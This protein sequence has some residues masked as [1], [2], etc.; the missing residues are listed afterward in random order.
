MRSR[1]LQSALADYIEAAGSHLQAEIVAGAE[2][3]YEVCS[4]AGRR[5]VVGTPLYCYRA[6]TGTFI[7]ERDAALKRL[8]GHADAA[9]ALEGFDGLE[10]YL[11]QRGADV[12]PSRGRARVRKAMSVL[13]EDVFAEQ[14][15]FKVRPERVRAAIGKLE[16]SAFAGPSQLTLVATL[17][18]LAICSPELQLAQGLAIANPEAIDGVPQQAST[19]GLDGAPERHLLVVHAAEEGDSASGLQRGRELLVE[20]L[21]ALRLFGDGRVTLGAVGWMRV[22]AGE[23]SPVAIGEGGRP[24]GMLLVTV[25]QE[26]ELRAFCNLIARRARRRDAVAWALRRFELGCGRDSAEEALS[27]HLLALR[28]LLEPEG[29]ASALLG[30]RLAALCATPERRAEMAERVRQAVALE[31]TIIAGG[32]VK[33][34]TAKALERELAGHLRALLS[35]VI[36][37]HLDPDLATLA[38]ELML[39][40]VDSSEDAA[41]APDDGAQD[42]GELLPDADEPGTD[43]GE[44]GAD[45]PEADTA[46]RRTPRKRRARAVAH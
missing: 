44:A 4:Q 13:L 16:S 30:G 22:G 31:R 10:R 43:G 40:P 7:A 11:A 36:C 18:G 38:D 9:K 41:P 27:D 39:A 42:A 45:G 29:S 23:W 15:D 37:G 17:H 6:L 26:D 34:A 14:T 12:A 19:A 8:P 32:A 2:V 35:D 24:H 33:Q 46:A 21:R 3:P 5:G 28:A 20:L 1:Q 25:E